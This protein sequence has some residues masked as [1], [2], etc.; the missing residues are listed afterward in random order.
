MILRTRIKKVELRA[1][2][3][4]TCGTPLC[5]PSCGDSHKRMLNVR[6]ELV[7]MVE[8]AGKRSESV[9]DIPPEEAM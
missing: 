5:C 6:E 8:V 7:R 2:V 4:P 1:T 9:A 3:C